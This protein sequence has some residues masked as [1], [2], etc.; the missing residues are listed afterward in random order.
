MPPSIGPRGRWPWPRPRSRLPARSLRRCEPP[1]K[2]EAVAVAQAKV[3]Q[4]EAARAQIDATLEKLKIKSPIDGTVTVQ[5]IHAGEVA[6][7]GAPLFTV[8][9]LGRLKLVVYVPTG[10]IGQVRLGQGVD[11]TVDAYPGRAFPGEVVRVADQA[12]F[13]PKNVQTQE[14]RV[15]TV[16]AVE[17]SLDNADGSLKAGMPA[18]AVLKP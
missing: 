12:E 6:Q 9:D 10:Q 2:A 16:F 5:S 7:P 15:K 3:A 4:A 17:I 11:V 18:D 14:E 8:A 1:R 13:T